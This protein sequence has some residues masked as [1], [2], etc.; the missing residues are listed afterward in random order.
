[1]TDGPVY[2]QTAR[3][4]ELLEAFKIVIKV[5]CCDTSTEALWSTND[6]RYQKTKKSKYLIKWNNPKNTFSYIILDPKCLFLIHQIFF[7]DI[8]TGKS[9]KH[10][11]FK[12]RLHIV[13][14]IL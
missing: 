8:V 11:M 10:C 4:L 1:M 7:K 12:L 13:F 6:P 5:Q 9:I 14:Q 3:L 2:K